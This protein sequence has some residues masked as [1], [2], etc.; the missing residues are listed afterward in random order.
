MGIQSKKPSYRNVSF[1]QTDFEF[2]EP[3]TTQ[4]S[5]NFQVKNVY[6]E[7]VE[8]H[9]WVATSKN[10]V[11]FLAA[12]EGGKAERAED[13]IKMLYTI[14]RRYVTALRAN[15][16]TRVIAMGFSRGRTFSSLRGKCSVDSDAVSFSAIVRASDKT[17]EK[18]EWSE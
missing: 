13:T 12:F 14:I 7:T 9:A 17:V 2:G 1:D 16:I 11:K 18:S 3:P 6:G 10:Y 15:E 5:R 4:K 8:V